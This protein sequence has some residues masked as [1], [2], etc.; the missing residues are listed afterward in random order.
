M[1]VT[2]GRL[3]GVKLIEPGV[4]KDAR[5]YFLES[6]Q[7]IRYAK[8]GL[9]QVFVQDNHSLSKEAGVI[10]GLHYQLKPEAQSKLVRVTAG[11]IYDVVVDIRQGSPTYGQWEGFELSADN[12]RQLF[13]PTGFAHGFCTLVPN[14]EVQYKV[15]RLYS[16][17]HDRGILWNDPAIGIKWPT[18]QPILSDKDAGHPV[19]AKAEHNFKY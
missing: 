5:G 8:V 18:T 2:E 6:Y 12:K 1:K 17:E 19:L 13:V 9:P 4:F 7:A 16:K 3:A 15:D 10:R 11:V 14:T